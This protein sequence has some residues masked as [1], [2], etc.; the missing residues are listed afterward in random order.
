MK[1]NF[2]Q[3]DNVAMTCTSSSVAPCRQSLLTG[4]FLKC[5]TNVYALA[6]KQGV[7]NVTVYNSHIHSSVDF[8][9]YGFV[10]QLS[11][12]GTFSFHSIVI[13]NVH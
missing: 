6:C 13:L 3:K 12:N 5:W 4:D 11:R 7:N 10:E 8:S 2:A 1:H 9:F